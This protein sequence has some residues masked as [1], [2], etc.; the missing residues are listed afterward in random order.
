M[1]V[2]VKNGLTGTRTGIDNR[3]VATLSM[4]LVIGDTRGSSLQMSQ[5]GLIAL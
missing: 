1:H 4:S 3:T 2:Q 5:Q